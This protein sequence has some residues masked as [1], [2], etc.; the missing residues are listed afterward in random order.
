[1]TEVAIV[2]AGSMQFTQQVVSDLVRRPATRDVRLSLMD[3][4]EERLALAERLVRRIQQEAGA[5][6]PVRA[7][8]DLAEAL[9]G[10]DFCLN[11]IQVGGMAATE[12]DFRIPAQYGIRQTIADTLG[13][14]GISRA[15]RTIPAV[16]S[17][18]RTLQAVA[19]DAWLLNY[20]NPMAMVMWALSEEVPG[21]TAVGLCHSAEYTARSLAEYLNLPFDEVEWLSAGINHMAWVLM[22]RRQGEDLYPRLLE[23]ARDPAV[24][25]RDP[26]RFELLFRFGRFVTESSEHNAEYVPYFLPYDDEVERLH[27]PIDEYLRRSHANLAKFDEL[28]LAVARP[29]ASLLRPPSVEYAPQIIAARVT[30]TPYVFYGNVVNAGSIDNLP[31]RAVVEVPCLIHGGHLHV[32]RVGS[33]PPG[34]AALNRQAIGVQ[35]LTVEAARRFDRDLLYQAASLDPLVASRLR[36]GEIRRLVDDLLEAGRAWLP[37]E[38][39]ST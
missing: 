37:R 36:L 34:P 31:P 32:T 39:F 33:L 9:T 21:V 17:I 30:K 38:W 6:G 27:I 15:L 2:G 13:I 5:N 26:V 1:M 3:I 8:R 29:D 35:E 10:V 12:M 24:F 28:K 23:R 25:R 4:D 7:S 22:L 16:V 11:E 18:A 19:P 14:G 20:T